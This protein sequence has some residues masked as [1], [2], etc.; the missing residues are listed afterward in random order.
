MS[1]EI[2]EKSPSTLPLIACGPEVVSTS[3]SLAVEAGINALARG[4]CAVDAALTAAICLTVVEP[5]MNGIGGDLMAL[6]WHNKEIQALEAVGWSPKHWDNATPPTTLRGWGTVTV[7]GQVRGWSSLSKR[8]GKLKWSELFEPAQEHAN[9]GFLVSE[10]TAELWNSLPED[11]ANQH[12]FRSEFLVNG[13]PQRG[14]KFQPQNIRH[15]LKDL[16]QDFGETFYEG[17]IASQIVKQANNAGHP[18]SL[19]DL[20]DWQPQWVTPIRSKWQQYETIQM[21]PPSQGIACSLAL[22]LFTAANGLDLSTN[23]LQ[24][25]QLEIECMKAAISET[26]PICADYSEA[27][28]DAERVLSDENVNRL[29][30][31]ISKFKPSHRDVKNQTG[32]TVLV[33]TADKQGQVCVLIQSNFYGFGSGIVIDDY[34]ISLHNRGVG[35]T[36]NSSTHNRVQGHKKPFHTLCPAM[37]LDNKG[38]KYGLGVMGGTLQPQGQFQV[39]SRLASGQR[40]DEAIASRRWR[41]RDTNTICVEDGFSQEL[42]N[43]LAAMGYTLKTEDSTQFGGAQWVAN[44]NDGT[45]AACCDPRKDGHAE[46]R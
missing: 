21:P 14:Q 32:G 13:P 24:R 44:T 38:L 23:S 25:A 16:S 20:K 39:L 3:N 11:L 36:M 26:Q 42:K 35:F 28:N 29:L 18:W 33:V 46:A 22:K 1:D 4:G 15:A 10:K 45:W 37:V 41:I 5:T 40:L 43:G 8:F 19:N 9:N 7:P 30:G 34:G 12:G 27:P 17:E 31:E 2:F 6:V